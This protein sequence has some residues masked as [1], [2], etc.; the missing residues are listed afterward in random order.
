MSKLSDI[1][2]RAWVNKG[3]AIGG[4]SDGNGLTF[5]L[6]KAGTASWVLRYRYGGKQKELTL[7]RY[8]DIT[9]SKAR[10]LAAERRV[11]IHQ[12]I[13]VAA[14]KQE[15][16]ARAKQKINFND[17]AN[18]WLDHH[19]RRNHKHPR[20]TERVIER[21]LLPSLSKKDPA[22]ITT[23]EITNILAKI[24]ASG[25]P[26]ISNDAL[27]HLKSIFSYG[28][29]LGVNDSNPAEKIKL[30]HAGGTEKARERYLTQKELSSF[31]RSIKEAS[32]S[33][34]RDNQLSVYLLLTF[35]CRKMELLGAKWSEFDL[36]GGTWRI[37]STRTK[38]SE[39]REHPLPPLAIDWLNELKIRSCN[40]DYVFPARRK[41]IRF[42]HVSP[43]TLWRAVK[44]LNHGLEDFNVHDLRRT[45]RTL[46][47][48]LGIPFDVAEKLVGHKLPGVAAIYDRGN[49]QQQQLDALKR[50]TNKINELAK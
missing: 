19:V 8:P 47:A 38:T 24:T 22:K 35:G 36:E 26:T 48:E 5:T 18:L 49:S 40:S 30:K 34:G 33:F 10:E 21:E 28:E 43:D 14:A 11:Q 23:A 41:S 1:Q 6:S 50:I 31:L 39:S 27:R 9:L 3:A 20:V 32:S 42:G 45:S 16:I 46:M 4:K 12:G 15:N 17:L 13:D 2:L 29:V 25:R 7:G 44:K 37:P